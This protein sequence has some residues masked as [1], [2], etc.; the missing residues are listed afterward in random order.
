MKV[1]LWRGY[2]GPELQSLVSESWESET[3]LILC[4][5]LLRDFRFLSALPDGELLF[6]GAWSEAERM[7]AQQIRRS[8]AS[9]QF[10]G[11]RETPVLGVFTSGTLSSQPR[12]VLYSRR[13]VLASLNAIFALFDLS[14]IRHVFCYPQ[15]FHTFGLTLGYLAAHLH[16]WRLHTPE[17]KYSSASHRQRLALREFEVLTLGTPTHFF[18]LLHTCDLLGTRP[19]PS[20]TCILGGARVSRDLWQR[21]K[22]DL[23]IKAPSVGYGCT[24]AA[25]GITHLPPGLEP[26]RDE[27]I[28]LALPSLRWE[29]SAERGVRISGDSLCIG[30]FEN[31]RLQTPDSLWIR[32]HIEIGA[33]A[34]WMYHGR[35][36]LSVNRGGVKYSLEAL[37]NRLR[38]KLGLEAVACGVRDARLGEDVAVALKSPTLKGDW[39]QV[40]SAVQTVLQEDFGLS[41]R[42]HHLLP[43]SDLPLTASAKIDRTHIQKLFTRDETPQS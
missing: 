32:D 7:E 20:Y 12:L 4:P 9:S 38:D 42:P 23:N 43:L 34:R 36:D 22:R 11:L 27:D 5:P 19:A 40:A 39:L 1:Q 37:E 6:A 13:N 21:V 17:G 3:L 14:Q 18:D 41:I 28:G 8:T 30:I 26:S 24:E 2:H 16:S 29:L 33:E 15:A 10:S 25:P 35:L 31:G